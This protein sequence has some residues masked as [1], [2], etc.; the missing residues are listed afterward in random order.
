LVAVCHHHGKLVMVDQAHAP[1]APFHPALQPLSAVAAGADLVTTSL[2]K[3]TEAPSQGSLLL[4]NNE[5]LAPRFLKALHA[6]PFISTS[7]DPGLVFKVGEVVLRLAEWGEVLLDSA[8]EVANCLREA[9]GQLPGIRTWGVEQGRRPGFQ[10]MDHLRVTLDTKN[11]GVSGYELAKALTTDERNRPII[12]EL[13]TISLLLCLVTYGN[14][15]A[16]AR[17]LVWRLNSL[18]AH[19][20]RHKCNLAD[21]LPIAL[22]DMPA[23]QV[24]TPRQAYFSQ[25]RTV[26]VEEAIDMVSAETIA[27]YPPGQP[28][29]VEG[30]RLSREVVEYLRTMSDH[31]AYLKSSDPHFHTVRVIDNL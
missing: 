28:V 4:V 7:F 5:E 30:E 18:V 24:L 19:S 26:P 12:M 2:H 6:T 1:H 15:R 29:A 13:E 3:T 20:G 16:E 21:Q 11:S 17:E 25:F 8:F 27:V 22:P 14:T 23:K 31:G 9:A 10:N